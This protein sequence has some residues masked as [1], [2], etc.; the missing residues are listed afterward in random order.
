MVPTKSNRPGLEQLIM[1][2][3]WWNSVAPHQRDPLKSDNLSS[4]CT[5]QL[6]ACTVQNA[7]NIFGTRTKGKATF[8]PYPF[9]PARRVTRF[10]KI[11]KNKKNERS[12]A[13]NV[14]IY[15]GS[16][17]IHAVFTGIVISAKSASDISRSPC[18]TRVSGLLNSAELSKFLS[19]TFAKLGQRLGRLRPLLD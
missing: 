11:Y 14:A 9:G 3:Y 6:R 16:K 13:L 1:K 12:A 15:L 17:G 10:M 2:R 5:P 4:P 7:R 8:Y 19:S 18:E